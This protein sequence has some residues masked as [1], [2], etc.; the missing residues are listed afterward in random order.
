[1]LYALILLFVQL[2]YLAMHHLVILVYNVLIHQLVLVV[3]KLMP[4]F[5][6]LA[7]LAIIYLTLHVYHVLVIA[8]NVMLMV[9][10]NLNN[11]L[12]RSLLELMVKI[13]QQFVMLVVK[14]VQI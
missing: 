3:A 9:V 1:M 10:I 11:Q 13:C 8:Q 7:M 14:N 12:V 4:I 6:Y 2:V 5:V